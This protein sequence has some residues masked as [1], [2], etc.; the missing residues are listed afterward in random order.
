VSILMTF[1][2]FYC[3]SRHGNQLTNGIAVDT[4]S[5][6]LRR[7]PGGLTLCPD[8]AGLVTHSV[9]KRRLCPLQPKPSCKKC[10]IHCYDHQYREKIRRIMAFSGRRLIMRGRVHYLWYYFF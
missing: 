7:Y 10:H 1:V 5:E 8:C 2:A 3:K 6:L 4:P 9:E